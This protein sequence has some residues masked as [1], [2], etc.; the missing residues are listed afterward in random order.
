MKHWLFSL[1]I[2]FAAF[3]ASP[4]EIDIGPLAIDEPA[5]PRPATPESPSAV[6]AK[7]Q[8]ERLAELR[9]IQYDVRDLRAL[10]R[11]EINEFNS[12]R[13][14]TVRELKLSESR[15]HSLLSEQDAQNKKLN[16]LDINRWR[17]R[18]VL[19]H[20]SLILSIEENRQ[21]AIAAFIRKSTAAATSETETTLSQTAV[22]STRPDAN[23]AER[24]TRI[25]QT[26]N[27]TYNA[28]T[29]IEATKHIIPSTDATA[30]SIEVDA[31]R[32]G[33]LALAHQMPDGRIVFQK[34]VSLNG[35]TD[36]TAPIVSPAESNAWFR[37]FNHILR[38]GQAAEIIDAI[39]PAGILKTVVVSDEPTIL[40][41]ADFIKTQKLP[42]ARASLD[43]AEP[44]QDIS[45]SPD[46]MLPKYERSPALESADIDE[47]L[48]AARSEL[49]S[50]RDI[51]NS[52]RERMAAT[53]MADKSA[54]R[55]LSEISSR[56]EARVQSN[57]EA[58]SELE[59]DIDDQN[60]I[61][62]HLQDL[63]RD[64]SAHLAQTVAESLW[65]LSDPNIQQALTDFSETLTERPAPAATVASGSSASVNV[66]SQDLAGLCGFIRRF[67]ESTFSIQPVAGDVIFPDGRLTRADGI[68]FGGLCAY[69]LLPD[70]GSAIVI[71]D[72]KTNRWRV[73]DTVLT[74]HQSQAMA[75][76]L[77]SLLKPSGDETTL[78]V[79]L[80]PTGGLAVLNAR[81]RR[82]FSQ[83]FA[84][85]GP[86]M[87]VIAVVG[88]V[89]ALLAV[90]KTLSLS[91]IHIRTARDRDII[92]DAQKRGD[93]NAVI[94]AATGRNS[95]IARVALAGA[96]AFDSQSGVKSV[97]AV[98]TALEEAL[99]AETPALEKYV[100]TLALTAAIA[101]LLGL[102]G[103]VTGM[104]NTFRLLTLTGATD[105]RSLS[106]GI[107]EAMIT[108]QAGLL[109]AIPILLLHGAV[110]R[111]VERIIDELHLAAISMVNRLTLA[112]IGA[113]GHS[114]IPA[115]DVDQP[116]S[117]SKPDS[118][119][120]A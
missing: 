54:A 49:Q 64:T 37:D 3:T 101:P 17:Q 62:A 83:W 98:E 61:L 41:F 84:D 112:A 106:G 85:G 2:G 63:I 69:V 88:I 50:L 45:D 59:Y 92:L 4:S 40:A 116:T 57:R 120:G 105:P 39:F 102:L 114:S 10:M 19:S 24:L 44:L 74:N 70:G 76:T 95:A 103:T 90:L 27:E 12:K 34:A 38:A 78:I 67:E 99:T 22:A 66:I 15:V 8:A 53:A 75:K 13:D 42:D 100:D 113:N 55:R 87:Y 79:P 80:D 104:I 72:D 25:S 33:N 94:R 21:N 73:M 7:R 14:E 118:E 1:A 48:H 111:G 6:H 58:I 30:G 68:V 89:A 110:R 31:I 107:S 81:S 20:C 56:L 46:L 9:R 97:S 36:M 82:T 52:N 65:A 23:L 26:A 108:T 28:G 117:V 93:I 109:V 96:T 91:L 35:T 5:P 119:T 51:S 16:E 115:P 71:R 60:R 86:L 11:D 18:T 47:R 29:V 32:L 77:S 43:I